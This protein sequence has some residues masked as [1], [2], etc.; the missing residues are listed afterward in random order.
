M[1]FY[2]VFILSQLAIFPFLF[3]IIKSKY[4]NEINKL[5]IFFVVSYITEC[6]TTI[7]I[8]AKLYDYSSI[9]GNLYILISSKLL[10]FKLYFFV[11]LSF[12]IIKNLTKNSI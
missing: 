2:S 4:S 1:N 7:L 10:I 5:N 12:V 9:P 11:F 3:A 8:K 6:I